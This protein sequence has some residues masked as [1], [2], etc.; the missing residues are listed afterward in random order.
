[1]YLLYFAISKN[2]KNKAIRKSTSTSVEVHIPTAINYAVWK[3]IKNSDHHSYSDHRETTGIFIYQMFMP[4]FVIY[5]HFYYENVLLVSLYVYAKN[6]RIC[7]PHFSTI[8]NGIE[9][10]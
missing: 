5:E 6:G 9:R 7:L 1:M 4:F 3:K 8:K 2:E 10:Y